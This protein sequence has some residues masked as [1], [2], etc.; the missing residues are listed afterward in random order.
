[1]H[2]YPESV[3]EPLTSV[4]MLVRVLILAVLIVMIG[5]ICLVA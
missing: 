2:K 3:F 5:L 1:M 4:R